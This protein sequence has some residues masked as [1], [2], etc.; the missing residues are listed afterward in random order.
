MA[1]DDL[2]AVV[3]RYVHL[4]EA[5]TGAQIAALYAQD[6][7]AEDPVGSAPKVGRAALTEFYDRAAA[8]DNSTELL[9]VRVAGNEAAAHFRVVARAG[10]A[11]Y[12]TEPIDTFRFNDAGEIV[13]MRAYWAPSDTTVS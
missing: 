2:R 12:T 3:Q 9:Q 5:G 6:G 11:T 4:I 7:R 8:M 1:A 13:E 10:E